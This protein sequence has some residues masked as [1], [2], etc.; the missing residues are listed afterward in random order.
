M[1][2]NANKYKRARY[3]N[4]ETV[5]SRTK[6]RQSRAQVDAMAR[7][8]FDGVG[9][10]PEASALRE[11]QDGWFNAVYEA[12]LAD[13]RRVI[14]KIAPPPDAEVMTYERGLMATEIATMRLAR[15]N[16]AIPVPAVLHH[17]DSCTL[18]DSPWF[19][20]ERV[21][22][23]NLDHV[24]GTW[25]PEV[26]GRIDR[27]LGAILRELNGLRGAWFG[28]E[29]NPALRGSSWR[30]VFLA[31]VESVL[32]DAARKGVR[33]DSPAERVRALVDAHAASLDD[34]REPRLVHWDS[35]DS[36]IFVSGD[37]VRGLIDFERA[38]WADPL[39]EALFRALAW[40]GVT[41]VMRGYGKTEFTDAELSRCWL[42]TLH[43]GLVMQTECAYRHYPDDE[44]R[45]GASRM[46]GQALDWLAAHG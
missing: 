11:L 29:G 5:D 46:V 42:Y 37:R 4:M 12:T 32:E 3:E 33:F 26:V 34:V 30:G 16:P 44:I 7:H 19:F 14:L 28:Y 2:K 35:W 20:M 38:L 31:I 27:H 23:D 21:A 18:C 9:L 22:C 36:N 40:S 41:E 24:R 15:A 45:A 6:N 25:P 43:L 8:A 10:A 13:G 1:N 39:M 17:D